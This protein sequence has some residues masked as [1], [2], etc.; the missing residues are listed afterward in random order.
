MSI[1]RNRSERKAPP[2]PVSGSCRW[3]K[4]IDE[5]AGVLVINGT[6]YGVYA[7]TDAGR[8]VGYRLTKADGT[9]YDIDVTAEYWSCDCP[10]YL[11]RRGGIDPKGCKHTAALRA[12]L[13]R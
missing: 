7:H 9:T 5:T 4:R 8:V 6:P 11:Y 10:D 2:R 13:G 1:L 3:A 12:A